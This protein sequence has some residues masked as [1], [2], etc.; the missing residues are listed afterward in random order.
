MSV[1]LWELSFMALTRVNDICPYCGKK[2]KAGKAAFVGIVNLTKET[3]NEDFNK[4]VPDGQFRI[5]HVVGGKP[6][7]AYHVEC[8]K[9][10]LS[11]PSTSERERWATDKYLGRLD[12]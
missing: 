1:A 4:K 6:R 5:R 12:A 10:A 3:V 9:T 7:G 8:I 2:I 11:Q